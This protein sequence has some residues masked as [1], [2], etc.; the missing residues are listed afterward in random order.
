MNYRHQAELGSSFT[1]FRLSRPVPGR[2][3][4]KNG[5]EILTLSMLHCIIDSAYAG[6]APAANRGV[7]I[8]PPAEDCSRPDQTPPGKVP[9]RG[10]RRSQRHGT[11]ERPG[12]DAR[13]S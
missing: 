7:K 12:K 6:K 13:T 8:D 9:R 2:T 11:H 10:Q 4:S 1:G 5:R 3:A